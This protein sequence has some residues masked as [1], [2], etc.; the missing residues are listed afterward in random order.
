MKASW[1][2]PEV[3]PFIVTALH[4]IL[5]FLLEFRLLVYL[6]IVYL[7][8]WFSNSNLPQFHKRVGKNMDSWAPP[9]YFWFPGTGAG[10]EKCISNKFSV[11]LLDGGP[12]SENHRVR[13]SVCFPFFSLGSSPASPLSLPPPTFWG[14][15]S[16][17]CAVW[18]PWISW[19]WQA[20]EIFVEHVKATALW[21][22]T[23]ELSQ[24]TC[25]IGASG[26]YSLPGVN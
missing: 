5:A 9:Q 4:W 17:E 25:I 26:P 22:L 23:A 24:I 7:G 14:H 8:Q 19:G 16:A 12:H 1:S 2:N 10:L 13:C 18:P 21:V 3:F 15:G 6:Y 20:R 11:M